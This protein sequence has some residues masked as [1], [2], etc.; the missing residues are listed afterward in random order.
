MDDGE[1]EVGLAAV[2]VIGDGL[3]E[4]V[5]GGVAFAVFENDEAEGVPCGGVGRVDFEAGAD[6]GGGV[7]EAALTE[8]GDAEEVVGEVVIEV[9]GLGFAEGFDGGVEFILTE[10]GDAEVI[11]CVDVLRFDGEDFAEVEFS[12][13]EGAGFEVFFSGD[14]VGF[15]FRAEIGAV[16]G[17][18]GFR[19]GVGGGIGRGGGVVDE[20]EFLA[21]GAGHEFIDLSGGDDLALC[22]GE[23]DWG[24]HFVDGA[25]HFI[26]FDAEVLETVEDPVAGEFVHEVLAGA[27]AAGLLFE[28]LEDDFAEDLIF[29]DGFL[30]GE[31][32]GGTGVGEALGGGV[33]PHG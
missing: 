26:G 1:I 3:F 10:L 13:L 12:V 33:E 14:G 4:V 5:A 6:F 11:E 9:V 17:T 28:L 27:F 8:V 23:G 31:G 15:E 2:R 20:V 18:G 21:V 25:E 22:A 19:E 30:F 7:V 16:G 29:G 32:T 24:G